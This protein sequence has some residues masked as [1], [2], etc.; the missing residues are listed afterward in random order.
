MAR[1][2][3][4]QTVSPTQLAGDVP[5]ATVGPTTGTRRS[6]N[7]PA[8][9][10]GSRRPS[11]V[12]WRWWPVLLLW[13][14]AAA[15]LRIANGVGLA[16]TAGFT[17][18]LV[19]MVILPGTL[20]WRAL[21][22]TGRG[23]RELDRR[24]LA[25]DV[26]LGTV[27]GY[28]LELPVYLLA[29]YLDH[30]LAEL[31]W[32]VVVVLATVV[33][34]SG[35][36]VW[37]RDPEGR[38][39]PHWWSAAMTGV[40]LLGLVSITRFVWAPWPGNSIASLQNP[41]VDVPYHLALIGD[42]RHHFPAEVPYVAGTPLYYHWLVYAHV[43]S[44][45]WVTGME[46][47]LLFRTFSLPAVGLAAV[48]AAAM[49]AARLSGRWWA[50]L[51]PAVGLTAMATPPLF[52][53][54]LPVPQN[55][56]FALT[57]G[58]PTQT[59]ATMIATLTL[60]VFVELLRGTLR[61]ARWWILAGVAFLAL[62]GSKS[63]FPPLLMAGLALTVLLALLGRRLDRRALGLLL[64]SGAGFLVAQ[65]VFY[66]SGSRSLM[67]W[68]LHAMGRIAESEPGLTVDH[69]VPDGVRVILA[70]WYVTVLAAWAAGTVGFF[71]RR[72]WQDST[73]R[74]LFGTTTAALLLTL[75]LGHP[76]LS[77]YYF[78]LSGLVPTLILST[79]GL[80]RLEPGRD[81]APVSRVTVGRGAVVV[82]L[83]ALVVSRLFAPAISATRSA[84]EGRGPVEE[85]VLRILQPL[86]LFWAV[87]LG[88]VVLIVVLLRRVGFNR[89]AR[90]LLAGLFLLGLTLD[91]Q[92]RV[93]NI[94]APVTSSVS[95]GV[96][97]PEGGIA[98]ARYVRGHSLPGDLVA[99]NAH[100]TSGPKP[101]C[102]HRSFWVSAFSERRVLVEGWAYIPLDTV[103]LKADNLVTDPTEFWDKP[104]LTVNEAAFYHP[105]P[106]NLRALR[107]RYD[108][109]WLVVDLRYPNVNTTAL[110]VHA[111][112]KFQE[113]RTAV[114][115][116][117]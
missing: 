117:R 32:P 40:V 83:L 9:R 47:A 93:L 79:L 12:P 60:V 1:T 3:H 107:S 34:R 20:I 46:P 6:S 17:A 106:A 33:T 36:R 69:T 23:A 54:W 61:T 73:A 57:Y 25:E 101:G 68:P 103:G 15:G 43:A 97:L 77:E 91:P 110:K 48:V 55:T 99:T 78:M 13:T 105:T 41:Y 21:R 53:S 38:V 74:F 8:H 42:L 22:L 66:G 2:L 4:S 115:Q 70:V 51:I 30:P 104:K 37:A 18:Y 116:L 75:L 7:A 86:G 81:L 112:L 90:V 59:Y 16:E 84:D 63:A 58:S 82:L 24:P 14:Y 94:T 71:V 87:V 80:A 29:R 89:D 50:G 26:A 100:C 72:G 45:S 88:V 98:A 5:P 95:G 52:G 108:V 27:L 109:K 10:A 85:A 19:G 56:P 11:L 76:N 67:V 111:R 64:L 113:G 65:R 62:A 39:V 102:T 28:I 35:R 31:A 114:F 44:A 92:V 49:A 96:V